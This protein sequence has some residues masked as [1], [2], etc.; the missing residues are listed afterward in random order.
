MYE[1]ITI[2]DDLTGANA[3]GVLLL[4]SGHRA[5][6]I[7]SLDESVLNTINNY[8]DI[9]YSTESREYSSEDAYACVYNAI[10]LIDSARKKNEGNFR[11]Y[12]KRI[13][14]TLRG[15]IGQEIDA[16]LDYLNDDRIAVVV[17]SFPSASRIVKDGCLFINRIKLSE[18]INASGFGS[19]TNKSN[20]KK[21]I[22]TQ[23]KRKTGG[24]TYKIVGHGIEYLKLAI[25]K[26]YR[27]GYRVIIF[28][29]TSEQEISLISEAVLDS[30]IPFLAVDPG[31]FTA[32]LI[33]ETKY[34]SNKK[35]KVMMAVGS[36][37]DLT[38]RQVEYFCENNKVYRAIIDVEKL[39]Y[40]RNE[41]CIEIKRLVSEIL[42]NAKNYN[43]YC[44]IFSSLIK[45]YRINFNI[46]TKK[47]G[48][49][50]EQI[51]RLINDSLAKVTCQV[52]REYSAIKGLFCSGGDTA[53]AISK[54][55]G[56]FGIELIREVIPL[57]AFGFL[58]GGEHNNLPIVTKG[59][60]VGDEK[61]IEKCVHFLFKEINKN[62]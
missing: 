3:L 15:N 44:L 61:A 41:R 39:I 29:A 34:S 56:A 6:T 51:L 8:G 1:C 25:K 38:H 5:T 52:L 50:K 18:S 36:V 19:I 35:A 27:N 49:P 62:R 12:S 21:I 7:F 16:M 13:D 57:V 28:D 32:N 14:T 9:I 24:I 33:K 17:P 60:L 10:S 58:I 26:L 53:I 55:T 20:V 45:D 46:V 37:T 54:T 11:V 48:L 22:G 40:S 59:G 2:A 47:T 4:K 43:F 31:P 42:G 30:S 23:S